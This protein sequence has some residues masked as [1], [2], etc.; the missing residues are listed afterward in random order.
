[1]VAAVRRCRGPDHHAEQGDWY[2]AIPWGDKKAACEKAGLNYKTASEFGSVC[3]KYEIPVRTGILTFQHHQVIAALPEPQRLPLRFV[4]PSVL[5]G[6][7][8]G[9]VR[10]S[11]AL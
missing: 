1:M 5:V 3:A 6:Q 2:N 11:P 8:C 9:Q 4:V 10:D 7:D